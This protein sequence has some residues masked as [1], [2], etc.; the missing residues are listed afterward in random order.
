MSIM[1]EE[2]KQ[3]TVSANPDSAEYWTT[4]RK[5]ILDWLKDHAPSFV[6]G[7]KGAL[8]LL[9]MPSDFPA[10]VHLICHLIRDF[11]RYLPSALGIKP[12]SRPSEVFPEMVRT[13]EKL[14]TNN[15]PQTLSTS[16]IDRI[17]VE[18]TTRTYTH[19]QGMV[20]K[21]KHFETTSIGQQF[22]Q[23][24][25]RSMEHRL[26]G[27][28]PAWVISSFDAEYNFFVGR[29]HLSTS[30]DKIPSDDGLVEHFQTFEKAFH[31]IVGP[32]FKGKEELDVIL[33]DT[34]ATTD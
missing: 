5:E 28:I 19:L 15:P 1:D 2:G 12:G 9:H 8:H 17:K 26:T 25:F 21:R 24:L 34:N 31:A 27:F 29:A 18:M 10:R 16:V 33:Q 4:E 20:N 23:S 13:L 22:A 7:Y 11:Y 14:W 32:Y 3:Q 30:V 6:E